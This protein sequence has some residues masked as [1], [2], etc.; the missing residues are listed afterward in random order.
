M[1]GIDTQSEPLG[2]PESHGP[3]DL[4]NEYVGDANPQVRENVAVALAALAE[5]DPAAGRILADMAVRDVNVALQHQF[6]AEITALPDEARTHVVSCLRALMRGGDRDT[7]EAANLLLVRLRARGVSIPADSLAD[8]IRNA[9]RQISTIQAKR[10]RRPRPT[11][12]IATLVAGLVGSAATLAHVVSRANVIGEI[13]AYVYLVIGT[14]AVAAFLALVAV[15]GATPAYTHL[16]RTLD[17]VFDLLAVFTLTT[18]VSLFVVPLVLAWTGYE[19]SSAREWTG[20]TA[21]SAVAVGGLAAIVRVGTLLA[22]ELPQMSRRGLFARSPERWLRR[23]SRLGVLVE[24]ATGLLCGLLAA[25]WLSP[26]VYRFIS[27]DFLSATARVVDGTHLFALSASLPL[28]V[29]FALLDRPRLFLA[30]LS[31]DIKV[32]WERTNGLKPE[33]TVAGVDQR[34]SPSSGWPSIP[35]LWA[36]GGRRVVQVAALLFVA[37]TLQHVLNDASQ[38]RQSRLFSQSGALDRRSYWYLSLPAQYDFGV[39]FAQRFRAEATGDDRYP[40]SLVLNSWSP[41]ARTADGAPD[42]SARANEQVVESAEDRPSLQADLG[43]G[44]YSLHIR[45]VSGVEGRTARTELITALLN[46]W[47]VSQREAEEDRGI[48]A[49]ELRMTMNENRFTVGSP[50]DSSSPSDVRASSLIIDKIPEEWP[51]RLPANTAVMLI[52]VPPRARVASAPRADLTRDQRASSDGRDPSLGVPL[53]LELFSGVD[54]S[55]PLAGGSSRLI[56]NVNQAGQYTIRVSS[57]E[58]PSRSAAGRTVGLVSLNLAAVSRLV[59]RPATPPDKGRRLEDGM[60]APRE[61]T[62]GFWRFDRVP[63]SFT[64]RLEARQR[65]VARLPEVSVPNP[66]EDQ[67][68]VVDLVLSLDKGINQLEQDDSDPEEISRTL[69]PGEYTFRIGELDG[70]TRDIGTATLN[71]EFGVPETVTARPRTRRR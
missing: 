60:T 69:D 70:D 68:E 42:C 4:V 61:R 53:Q 17:A 49:Q 50:G 55:R 65:I 24:T 44:C 56:H 39:T 62:A 54:A 19:G 67:A 28:A 35:A 33:A 36:R 21:F 7:S 32:A 15:W 5:S 51:V 59:P 30:W 10:A 47:S 16:H 57:E 27:P 1:P 13:S 11:V 3:L 12:V 31:Q 63:A 9:W 18:L 66:F 45:D 38:P 8:T 22:S 52:V 71:L 43:W 46:S 34:Q 20:A 2:T 26:P 41:R 6:V 64:L 25:A 48:D 37:F 14:A 58:D 29:A 23:R 40:L